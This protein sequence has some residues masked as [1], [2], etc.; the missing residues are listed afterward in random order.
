MSL[1]FKSILFLFLTNLSLFGCNLCKIDIPNVHIKTV[2]TPMSVGTK[3]D[4][5]WEFDSKF[6]ATLSQY[7]TNKNSIFE[8]NEQKEINAVLLE[9]LEKMGYLT[10][11]AFVKKDT[12][13]TENL[14]EKITNPKTKLIFEN[15][16]MYFN[17]NFILPFVVKENHE[18]ILHFFDRGN[19][20]NFIIKDV[21]VQEYEKTKSFKIGSN[22]AE[23]YFYEKS[24]ENNTTK[25]SVYE[26]KEPTLLEKLS[27]QLD[28]Y[29]SKIKDLI[30]EIEKE[31]ELLAYSWLLLFS[32]LYGVLHAIGPGHGK[33][34]VGA[35]FL[36][37][38]HSLKK[39]L[40]ISTMI[41]V[42]H[43]LSAFV[44]TLCIYFIVD[45]LFS[46]IFT[47]VEKIATQI[48]GG[49]IILIALTLLYRK[50][51][52]KPKMTFST[53]KPLPGTHTSCGCNSCT[54][55]STDLGVVLGAGIVPCAGTVTIFLF[56]ISLGAY[57]VGFLSAIF[58]SIGMSLVIFLTAY[59]SQNIRKKGAKNSKMVKLFEYGSLIFILVL[60]IVLIF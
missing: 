3:F 52:F 45:M 56:T 28:I 43:T 22:K 44:F 20:F 25:L 10:N 11:I 18:M 33:S 17:Y 1:F 12:K 31:N 34:L 6:V 21:L 38:N 5:V 41:G 8:P 39:A 19:N 37:E 15:K 54:T 9:Y 49:V 53:Q 59:L 4:I 32:F 47:N 14:L 60:G 57:F 58:M 23:V 48:S 30:Q 36:S 42:V 40:G 13:I 55:N 26:E 46:N 2:I 27:T 29:K 51:T 24:V 7:D 50:Y 16:T 35:Y